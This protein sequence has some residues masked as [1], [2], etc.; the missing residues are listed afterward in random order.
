MQQSVISFIQMPIT[1]QLCG[2]QFGDTGY[3]LTLAVIYMVTGN[4]AVDSSLSNIFT[5]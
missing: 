4:K 5:L 1:G 3:A 2:E